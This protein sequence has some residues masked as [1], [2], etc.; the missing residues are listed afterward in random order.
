MNVKYRAHAYLSMVKMLKRLGYFF[1]RV[2]GLVEVSE[3]LVSLLRFVHPYFRKLV[4]ILV[5]SILSPYVE[6]FSYSLLVP[7]FQETGDFITRGQ[8]NRAFELL[9]RIGEVFPAEYRFFGL[10]LL[11]VGA[12][13]VKNLVMYIAL[14]S[15]S[16]MQWQMLTD[17]RYA[18]Q[19]Q[20]LS[21]GYSFIAK[22]K[23][24][25][26]LDCIG[27]QTYAAAIGIGSLIDLLAY[28]IHILILMGFLAYLS[29]LNLLLALGFALLLSLV[30]FA[31]QRN[32][33]K[34]GEESYDA[35]IKLNS[36][37]VESL[38]GMRTIRMFG[39]EIYELNRFKD[40]SEYFRRSYFK[41][42]QWA[43]LISGSTELLTITGIIG[44]LIFSAF[45][46]PNKKSPQLSG[47]LIVFILV[48]FRMLPYIMRWNSLRS[49]LVA[50]TPGII[51]T[52]RMLRKEGKPYIQGGS[53]PFAELK[54][55]IFFD[56]VTFCYDDRP[57][58]ALKNVC[59]K[60]RVGQTTALI[61]ESGAGKSTLV[62]LVFRLYDPQ[63]GTIYVD[64][65]DLRKLN[66]KQW[67]DRISVVSQDT[68]VFHDTLL[69][70]IRYGKLSANA[71]E[72]QNAIK[73]AYLDEFIR[74]LPN[75]LET[76]VGDRGVQLSGGQRQRLAIARAILNDDAKLL[77]FDEA[78]SEL[79]TQ[80]EKKIQE[81]LTYLQKGRTMI[82]IAHR[83]STVEHSDQI[84]VLEQGHVREVG[85]PKVLRSLPSYY[86]K[87][88]AQQE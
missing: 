44:I 88:L 11:I 57:D 4:V 70:N 68:F 87:L 81:V 19:N 12:I 40:L 72:I 37:Y 10:A 20:Y 49:G 39:R 7:L 25:A 35:S 42:A 56:N 38:N 41:I 21:V 9:G 31:I 79:D 74:S 84:V 58:P 61:G 29:L 2:V 22:R 43:N 55:G 69:E 54:E 75:G 59:L 15:S 28:S 64:G 82:T 17:L 60:I 77:I 85:N 33:R 30:L 5:L 6:L 16:W 66:L 18:V 36:Y 27:N 63:E 67:R 3:S 76:L 51:S 45:L 1:L 83:L 78:T 73:I 65:I 53:F 14:T 62:D 48:L 24:G 8:S 80:T 23:A 13:T 46:N 34:A 50:S 86:A 52:E 26:L 71:D 32:I 47:T